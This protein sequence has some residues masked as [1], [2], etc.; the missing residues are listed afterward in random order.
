MSA[1]VLTS[2]PGL[3]SVSALA[4]PTTWDQTWF[5]NFVSN[6]LKGGDVRNAIAGPGITITG[7][8]ASPYATISLGGSGPV[9]LPGLVTITAPV[10]GQSL[11]VNVNTG[12]GIEVNNTAGGAGGSFL[13]WRSAGVE[14]GFIGNGTSIG[15][16]NANDFGIGSDA[17]YVILDGHLGVKG[18]GPTA[19]VLVDM[20]PDTGTFTV[21]LT[22]CTTSPTATAV[23]A[24]IGNL[25]I[26][27][28]PALTGTSNT[29][30]M[31]M[32]GLPTEIQPSRD[33]LFPLPAIESG[34]AQVTTANSGVEVV[35]SSGSLFFFVNSN[36]SGFG[37]TLV[38]GLNGSCTFAYLLN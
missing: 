20:T 13:S 6:V 19:G 15:G 26:L 16:A 18:F 27:A 2:K 4:I 7:N 12:Q 38:K 1:I 28:L 3:Q 30:S 5:K 10:S 34:G 33:Q 35:A 11:L 9:T 25:V 17:G 29:T 23:W 22:G 8:L 36:F 21:T 24:R 31:T 14:V 32:T 37:N